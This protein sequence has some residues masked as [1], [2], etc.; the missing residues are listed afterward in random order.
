[1]RCFLGIDAGTSGIKAI[2]IDESGKVRGMGYRECDIITPQPGWVEQAPENWWQA[3]SEAAAQAV[4]AAQC[5]KDVAG[6]GFSGQMQG[7]TLMDRN[8]EPIGN[9][10]IWI[11]Q[12]AGRETAEI[13]AMT[14]GAEMLKIT[15]NSCLNSFWAPKLLWLRKNRP[16]D[17]DRAYKVLFTKDY[18][19]YKMTGEI[20]T[21][22]SDASLS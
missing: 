18:L 8:L 2:V 1:M 15:A 7:C 17:F 19:R 4:S 12:R 11:D 21:D 3:C 20:A 22:V 5:G 10:L 14:D 16:A 6:I 13:E 9:S